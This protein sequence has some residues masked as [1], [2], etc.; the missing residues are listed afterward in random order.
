MIFKKQIDIGLK[1]VA[2]YGGIT[3]LQCFQGNMSVAIEVGKWHLNWCFS[4]RYPYLLPGFLPTAV[5]DARTGNN[6][7]QDQFILVKSYRYLVIF[8][9]SIPTFCCKMN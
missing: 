6:A 4:S 3:P 9:N 5:L 7:S 1:T 8:S 2:S